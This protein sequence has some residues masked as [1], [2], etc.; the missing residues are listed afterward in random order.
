R[1][2][3]AV[4]LASRF[5]GLGCPKIFHEVATR[6]FS[7]FASGRVAKSNT[8]ISKVANRIPRV[9]MSRRVVE[10]TKETSSLVFEERQI[11]CDFVPARVMIRQS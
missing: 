6:L 11:L 3:T 7:V 10:V 8:T 2:I 9:R 5:W 1:G 4:A